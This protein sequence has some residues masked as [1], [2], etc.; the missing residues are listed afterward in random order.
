MQGAK[1]MISQ[2]IISLMIFATLVSA[3]AST[4]LTVYILQRISQRHFQRTYATCFEGR[5]YTAK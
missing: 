3:P 4:Q 2:S 5:G 1:K